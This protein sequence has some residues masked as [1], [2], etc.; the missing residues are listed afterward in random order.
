MVLAV[1]SLAEAGGNVAGGSGNGPNSQGGVGGAG[2]QFPAF[3]GS[4]IGVPAL[5]PLD[6]YYGGGGGGGSAPPGPASSGGTGGGE[7]G[8]GKC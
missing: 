1:H 4:H 2:Q 6:S 5:S 8:G 7:N 3:A